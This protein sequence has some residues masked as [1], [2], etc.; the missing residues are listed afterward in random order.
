MND[1]EKTIRNLIRKES[2]R[3]IKESQASF[4]KEESSSVV[5]Y[6]M[7]DVNDVIGLYE[8]KLDK[9]NNEEKSA[10]NK[11][12]YLE[13]KNIKT[14]QLDALSKM[15]NG[16]NQKIELLKSQ[17]E[18]LEHEIMNVATSGSDVFKHQEMNEFDN[19]SFQKDWGLRIELPNSYFNLVKIGDHNAYKLMDTNAKGFKIGDLL[20]LPNISIGGGGEV[21]VYRKV[22]DRF[23]IV[24]KPQFKNVNKL[25]KNPK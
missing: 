19:E 4:L 14:S 24:A 21:P 3:I 15:I 12:D 11:E 8:K 20:Q 10:K 7:E 6:S 25:I 5:K 2:L 17:K 13:L 18:E 1:N 22:G 23:E 9:L 16:Y